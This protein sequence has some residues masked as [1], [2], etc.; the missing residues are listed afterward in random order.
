MQ[1]RKEFY[2]ICVWPNGGFVGE[3]KPLAPPVGCAARAGIAI[4][5]QAG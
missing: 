4:N 2:A 1:V 5:V 3:L